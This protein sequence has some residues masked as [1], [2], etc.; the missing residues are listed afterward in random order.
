MS[1]PQIIVIVGPTASGKSALAVTIAKKFNGEIISADSRQVYKGL[2]IGSGK[3]TTTEMEGVPHHLLDVTNPEDIF[4]VVDFK[5]LAT[6]AINDI[7]SR[8]HLPIIVGG[9]GF[10]IDTILN[11]T[12]LPQVAPNPDLRQK[13]ASKTTAELGEILKRLDPDRWSQID[14][15]NKPRLIRAIEIAEVLTTVPKVITSE[16]LF[17]PLTI[18]IS[19]PQE[20]L[21]QKIK[22]RLTDRLKSGMI[23]EVKHL[24]EAG[25]SYA[26]LESFGLEYKY[27][28]YFLQNKM[29][30]EEMM[31]KLYTAIRQY[32][33]RQM[34]WWKRNKNIIWVERKNLLE[35]VT[36]L[37]DNFLKT[38]SN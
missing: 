28:A 13:L 32:S 36:L 14:Q 3:I 10:Y 16:P 37:V 8:N 38:K 17:N 6:T 19:I 15:K 4:T 34:T 33:K 20:D 26:R 18:G 31:G 2:D 29:S 1:K 12:T 24:Q 23:D 21:D 25:L 7:I 11:N 27:I 22:L 30:L 5:T 9:T 35:D